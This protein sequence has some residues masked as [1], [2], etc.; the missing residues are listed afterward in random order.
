VRIFS[1]ER[2]CGL[3]KN[4]DELTCVFA[5]AFATTVA[6][7]NV[8]RHFKNVALLMPC[9]RSSSATGTPLSASF[10]QL[11]VGKRNVGNSSRRNE[12][13]PGDPA[14]TLRSGLRRGYVGV[15]R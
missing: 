8:L 13:L 5:T 1:R 4:I 7:P 6:P 15:E 3:K 12:H 9:F 2:D 14:R 10:S 11:R